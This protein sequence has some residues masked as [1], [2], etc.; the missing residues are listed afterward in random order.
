[1]NRDA[2]RGSS[3]VLAIFVLVLIT[4]MGAALLFV[5]ETEMKMSAVDVR[6]KR[7][8]FISEAGLEDARET[9]RVENLSDPSPADRDTLDDELVS[10]AGANG[11][12]DF[13][14]AALK[15]LYAADGSVAGFTGYGDDLPIKT[16]TSFDGG[17][18]AAF[19]T[20]D[21]LD[22]KTSINDTNNRAMLTAIGTGPTGSIE[23]VQAIVERA[24]LPSMPATITILGPSADFDGGNSNAKLYM[25]DDCGLPGLSV[26]VVGVIGTGSE[27]SAE[28]GVQ[29]P[30]SYTSGGSTGNDTV[31]DIA[32]SIDPQWMDCD[33]LHDLARSVRA[34]ADVVGDATTSNASLGTPLDPRVVYIEGD[35][36]VG[37]GF[38]GAGLLFV[39]GVL[40]FHG[41]AA[42]E[43][44]IYT[45]GK[46][47][48]ER[49]GG[50]NGIISGANL[51][52]DVAGPDGIMWTAD[53]CAGAD[54]VLGTGDDGFATGI[55]HNNGGG[56]GDT[57]YCSQDISAV[58][59]EFPFGVV[60]FRQR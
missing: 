4:G 41:N 57:V 32:G 10:A 17:A 29:K 48:F 27:T 31:S 40:T 18:Y 36:T 39:T 59:W 8:F 46:G 11:T 16:T 14:P 9:L 23:I 26:P 25:G 6:A 19:L 2:E 54:G 47:Q 20:N 44:L 50:G 42:W 43:G 60:S 45:I 7:A 51:V 13:D 12:L 53:D 1:V 15:P 3:L 35:Y 52:A 22:G 5:T 56:T 33:Y 30:N 24:P 55:Y 49:S 21:P 38:N 37:G 34:A 28:A 58:E